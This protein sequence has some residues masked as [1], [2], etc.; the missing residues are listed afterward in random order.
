MKKIKYSHIVSLCSAILLTIAFGTGCTKKFEEFNSNPNALS[1]QQTLAA[2]ATAIGPIETNIIPGNAYQ[3][4]HN[5]NADAYAGY[6]MSPTNF[7][8]G[9][10]N[11]NYSM[12]DGWNAAAFSP[13]YLGVMAPVKKI[14]DA[15]ARISL[16]EVW[17]VALAVQVFAMDRVTDKFGPIPYTQAGTSFTHTPYDEQKT[18]YTAFFKQLDTAASNLKN[19]IASAATPINRLGANDLIYGG[20]YTKWLK[21][22]NSLRLRLA[23][24]IS[25][26]D[27]AMA[28]Q[29]GEIAL[30][31]QGGLITDNTDN[32]LLK[33]SG[34]RPNDYYLIT[35]QYV[36]DNMANASLGSYL[37]GYKDP[38]ARQMLLPATEG[39][40]N[41]TFMGIRTG[42][43]V[44]KLNYKTFSTY[45]YET[46][47]NRAA[48]QMLFNAAEVWFLK[49][50]AALRGWANTGTA[51]DNYET[52][53]QKSMEQWGVQVGSYLSDDLSKQTACIDP[54]APSN[55][56]PAV[57]TITI[58]WDEGVAQ[59]QK[60]ERIIT[61]K[62]L[63]IFPDGQEAWCDYRRTGYPK[64]FTAVQNKSNGTVDTQIG[65]RRLPF[66]LSEGLNNAQGLKF[67]L[68]ALGGPD[69]AGTRMWWDK[70]GPN[71]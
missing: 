8:A 36:R 49:A 23:M 7:V 51:K 35:F 22:V 54:L 52:G 21:F 3:L 50:E 55:S 10:N 61:Q 69:N 18:V 14:G 67:G 28:K 48:P 46:T 44:S 42:I 32:A 13:L 30:A 25:K 41:G 2:L 27:P 38:R 56:T 45:N 53:V 1:E 65:P 17:A 11:L 39:S 57:S 29:Q 15:G 34:N 9:T 64:L 4:Q 68:S 63:A 12:V 47:F 62:W 40:I 59:E 70:A 20:N 24:R 58:K 33:Q 71:F 66:I 60:L 19:Y 5:L 43:D 6:S 26:I 16:P 37:D 31:A